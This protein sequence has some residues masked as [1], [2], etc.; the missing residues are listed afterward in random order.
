MSWRAGTTL[1]WD[2]WPKIKAAMPDEEA[3]GEFTRD[4]LK[5]FLDHDTDPGDLRGRDP[6]INRLMDEVDPGR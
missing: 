2:F 1:F 6:E 5:A 3:R 4:L